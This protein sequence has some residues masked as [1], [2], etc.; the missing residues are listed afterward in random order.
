MQRSVYSLLVL[1]M[2]CLTA[3]P[4]RTAIWLAPGSTRDSLRFLISDRRGGE[5][6]IRP[7]ILRFE[8]C[9]A[10]NLPVWVIWDSLGASTPVREIVYGT[11]PPHFGENEP[12]KPL[13]AGCY[14]VGITGTGWVEFKI[15]ESGDAVETTKITSGTRPQQDLPIVTE[16]A[17]HAAVGCYLTSLAPDSVALPSDA[18]TPPDSIRLEARLQLYHS[19]D[20]WYRIAPD[21]IESP[22]YQYGAWHPRGADSLDIQWQVP[23]AWSSHLFAV[24]WT[25]FGYEGFGGYI[26]DIR[27]GGSHARLTLTRVSCD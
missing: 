24:R 14:R 16:V 12:A 13:A 7:A 20:G 15:T 4:Q 10:S 18:F 23:N 27:R 25:D 11:R 5:K 1:A 22:G 21:A 6:V 3:C 19:F 2:V 8:P 26:S 17:H 9:H